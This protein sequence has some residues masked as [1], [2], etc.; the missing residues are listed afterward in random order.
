MLKL[1]FPGVN[2]EEPSE[3]E[4][5]FQ[6]VKGLFRAGWRSLEGLEEIEKREWIDNAE[7]GEIN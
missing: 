2:D 4:I 3:H 1:G 6:R 5:M 7:P